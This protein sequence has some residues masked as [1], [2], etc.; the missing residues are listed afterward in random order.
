MT[1][2][3]AQP[4]RLPTPLPPRAHHAF[5]PKRVPRQLVVPETSLWFNLEVAARRWPNRPAYVF[6]GRELSY[7]QL[8]DQA[9][10]LAAWLRSAGVERGDRVAVFMQNL[11]QYVVTFYAAWRADA[12]VVP[13][14]PMNKADEFG[15]YITDPDTKIVVTSADLAPIVEQA[16]AALPAEQRLRGLLVTQVGEYLPAGFPASVPVEERPA[17]AVL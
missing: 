6:F 2:T 16:N 10:A 13:V 8:F 11:P 5:W 12:V 9:E 4:T 1:P 17:E 3:A 14:N 7:R 15:H